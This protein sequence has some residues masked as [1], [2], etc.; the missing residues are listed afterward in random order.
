MHEAELMQQLEA[1]WRRFD[2]ALEHGHRVFITTQR[3]EREAELEES[4]DERRRALGRA[5]KPDERLFRLAGLTQGDC[6]LRFDL[7][8]ATAARSLFQRCDGVFWPALHDQRAAEN[9]H[10]AD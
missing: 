2:A 7:R 1:H 5:L 3:F 9:F 8:V 4:S 10:R 6:Q